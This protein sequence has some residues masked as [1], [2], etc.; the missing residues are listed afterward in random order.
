[1]DIKDYVETITIQKINMVKIV[2]EIN[3]NNPCRI[4]GWTYIN[5][6]DWDSEILD[7]DYNKNM[8][9]INDCIEYREYN[10]DAVVVFSFV[11]INNKRL[12]DFNDLVDCV[13]QYIYNIRMGAYDVNTTKKINLWLCNNLE[14][15]IIK[16]R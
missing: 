15:L 3:T 16:Y 7:V 10:T 9:L 14:E 5:N 4:D 12:E 11:N 2:I 1:M 13:G 8:K 6:S